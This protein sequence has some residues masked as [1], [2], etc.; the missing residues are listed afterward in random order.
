MSTQSESA[1]ESANQIRLA[2]TAVK[3]AILAGQT[4]IAEALDDPCVQS[5]TVFQLLRSQ[6]RWGTSYAA[7]GTKALNL[8]SQLQIGTERR[9][10]DL[11]ERQRKILGEACESKKVVA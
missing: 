7:K 4:T 1:L 11:T 6:K 2:R 10:A 9:V 3:Q 5:M 8:L